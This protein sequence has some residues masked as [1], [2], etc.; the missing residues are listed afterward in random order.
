MIIKT[1]D[2]QSWNAAKVREVKPHHLKASLFVS[3]VWLL[4]ATSGGAKAAALMPTSEG[5]TVTTPPLLQRSSAITDW[6][7]W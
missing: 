7:S 4:T 3:P 5:T 6:S 2:K 1:L